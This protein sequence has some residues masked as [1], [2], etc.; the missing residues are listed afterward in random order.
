MPTRGLRLVSVAL[1]ALAALGFARKGNLKEEM[2]FGVEAA[3]RGLWREAIFRWEKYLKAHPDDARLR[4]NLAV[5][6]ESLGDF[7]RA[8]REYQEAR[9]LAPDV[10]EIRDN[11]ESFEALTRDLDRAG[12]GAGK[13]AR[14]ERP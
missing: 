10:R 5:A 14:D 13:G 9:R 7:E 11:F 1:I 4:N 8:R 12:P 3:Q 6:Y 2:Q